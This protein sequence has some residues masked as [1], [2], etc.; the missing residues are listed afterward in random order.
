MQQ[1]HRLTGIHPLPSSQVIES[2]DLELT[3]KR[4]AMLACFAVS[5]VLLIP[6]GQLIAG[7]L[8][9]LACIGLIATDP[10]TKLRRRMGILMGCVLLLGAIDINPSLKNENFIALSIP[11]ALVI[12]IPAIIQHFGD[13][14][15][16]RYRFWPVHWRKHDLIYTI[17]AIPLAWV[18]LK[19]YEWGNRE[20][21]DNELFRQWAMPAEADDR[22][23]R[24]LFVGINLVGIWDELFFVNTCFALL[25][26]LFRF[27]VANAIQAVIYTAVLYDMAFVGCGVFIV[28]L[29]AWTQ[30]SMFE[31]SESLLWVLIVHLIVDYFLVAFIV[32]HYYPDYGLDFLWRKGF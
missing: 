10:E 29:F 13:K 7:G 24:R 15:V 16:I 20:L 27:R 21:F 6:A 18:V 8:F 5:T 26:S 32:Q 12:T 2:L 14:G 19:S 4:K 1:R 31:K 3:P 23:I 30:G 9:S 11:F 25:R 17:L 28:F 22:E